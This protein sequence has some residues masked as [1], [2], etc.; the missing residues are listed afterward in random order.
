MLKPYFTNLP[1]DLITRIRHFAVDREVDQQ[2]IIRDALEAYL[3]TP[4]RTDR[5]ATKE[6]QS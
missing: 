4:L 6:A 2:V 5:P 1:A 3:N